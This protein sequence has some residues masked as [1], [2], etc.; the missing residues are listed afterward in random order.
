[1]ATKTSTLTIKDKSVFDFL[2]Q[3]SPVTDQKQIQFNERNGLHAFHVLQSDIYLKKSSGLKPGDILHIEMLDRT[4]SSSI[5][6]IIAYTFTAQPY[7]DICVLLKLSNVNVRIDTK[8]HVT[9][10]KAGY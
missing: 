5:A 8:I 1:M 6:L 10:I 3:H 9:G 4:T 2:N 7:D